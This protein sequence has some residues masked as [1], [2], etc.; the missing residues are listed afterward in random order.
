MISSYI[1]GKI[2][3]L[4]FMAV[5]AWEDYKNQSVDIR[6]FM[7][8]AFI[9][10]IYYMYMLAFNKE[11]R[12]KEILAGI[13]IGVAMYLTARLTKALGEGDGLFFII[14]G[15]A[16]GGSKNL[17]LFIIS[18]I[19]IACAGLCIIAKNFI[20]NKSSKKK[21]IAMLIFTLPAGILLLLV[22]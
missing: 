11:V 17:M 6:V 14:S 9:E 4:I 16:F 12:V 3:I 21:K 7:I 22:G 2:L 20:N 19:F 1:L 15:A 18:S 8:M 5:C 13:G 10:F